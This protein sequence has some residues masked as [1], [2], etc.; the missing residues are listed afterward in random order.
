MTTRQ[1]AGLEP[2]QP[3]LRMSGCELV[4]KEQA[5]AE[6]RARHPIFFGYDPALDPSEGVYYIAVHESIYQLM[7][8]VRDGK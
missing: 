8:A 5:D 2:M 6:N 3:A 7:L 4:T 1:A